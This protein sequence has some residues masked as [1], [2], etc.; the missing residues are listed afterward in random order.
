[1]TDH[2][3]EI[4]AGVGAALLNVVALLTSREEHFEFALRCTSL[5]IGIIVGLLTAAVLILRILH[6]QRQKPDRR[7]HE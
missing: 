5:F 1:M 6:R 4:W 7:T 2:P 3:G